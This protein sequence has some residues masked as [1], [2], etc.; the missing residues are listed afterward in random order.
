[1]ADTKISGLPS[2]TVPLAGT[3]V[4]PIVQSGTTKKVSIAD[5]TAGRAVTASTV[6][7]VGMRGFDIAGGAGPYTKT[8]T[9]SDLPSYGIF[10]VNVGGLG[11]ASASS[12]AAQYLVGGL[13]ASTGAQKTLV[14]VNETVSGDFT[15]SNL[16][17]TS[18]GFSVDVSLSTGLGSGILVTILSQESLSGVSVTFA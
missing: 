13:M 11:V 1:M 12:F 4:L 9:I 10:T 5:V 8:L 14:A 3:E 15:L 2:A 17:K 6:N 18:T 16:T 7:A